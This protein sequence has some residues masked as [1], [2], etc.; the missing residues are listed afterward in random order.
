MYSRHAC[1]CVQLCDMRGE[2]SAPNKASLYKM[3]SAL[4]DR[5][6]LSIYGAGDGLGARVLTCKGA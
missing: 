2:L 4:G 6:Q 1:I 3:A 5:S